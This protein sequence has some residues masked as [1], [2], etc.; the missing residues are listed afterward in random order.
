MKLEEIYARE[1]VKL[2]AHPDF[3]TQGGLNAALRLLAKWR[4]KLV[5]NTLVATCGT[6]IR[7]GPFQ[8]MDFV[9]SASEANVSPR[10]LG[11]YEAELHEVIE[12]IIASNYNYIVDIG[13]AD[14]YYA[15]GFA[16]RMPGVKV[17]AFDINP[18]AQ[19]L[20][21][22][23][24]RKNGLSD[25]ITIGGEFRGSDFSRYVDRDALVFM[26]AEGVE[27]VLLDPALYPALGRLSILVECHDVFKPSISRTLAD[28]FDAT[29]DIVRIEP[30]MR[31]CDLPP[32]FTNMSH[33]DQLL[34]IWEWRMGPTPWLY[35]TPKASA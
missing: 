6:T 9:A 25:R 4:S 21:A 3:V 1:L 10:I 2:T 35:L 19:K 12:R 32:V 8:G 30:K 28:R 16:Y 13:C 17:D 27:E 14:G 29:H 33:M 34:A 11:N 31:S 15:C 7:S 24:A 5:D 18:V 23:L 20:C 26:D 22:D